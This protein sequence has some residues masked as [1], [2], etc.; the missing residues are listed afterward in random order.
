M[1]ALTLRPIGTVR[2]GR[3]AAEDDA[4]APCVAEIVLVPR[5]SPDALLGLETFSHAEI[6]F[7]FHGVAE[8]E[9]VLAARHPRDRADSPLAGIFAQRGR[10]RPNRLGVTICEIVSV[11]GLVLT[12]RGLDAIDGTPVLDIKPYMTGFAARGPV[13][14]PAWA[15]ALMDDYW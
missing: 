7:H 8:S 12:V 14:E 3:I 11:Q 6:V 15:Q 2:G 4:W 5:F 1:D 13:R 10:S 9:E